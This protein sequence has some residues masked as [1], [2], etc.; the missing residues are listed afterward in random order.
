AQRFHRL[1]IGQRVPDA[2][3]PGDSLGKL[4]PFLG[5]PSLEELFGPL[6]REVE[7]RLHVDDRFAHDAEAK[8]ARLDDAGMHRSY[9]DLV[10]T[11][12]SDL[13]EGEGPTVV[14]E[15]PGRRVLP[16]REVV[17]GPEGMPDQRAG[18]RVPT[19]LN[20]VEIEDLPLES[21]RRIVERGQRGDLRA[22]GG[23]ADRGVEEPMLTLV[24]E[25]I[26]DLEPSTVPAAVVS[27]HQNQIGP[28]APAKPCR[29]RRDAVGRHR[30]IEPR[31]TD[32]DAAHVTSE[33]LGQSRGHAFDHHGPTISAICVSS[34]VTGSGTVSP[35]PTS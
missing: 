4:D 16:E 15:L 33:L 24:S 7:A 19:G 8:V 2:R 35:R 29:Q 30:A 17:T 12:A 20:A 27:D 32:A 23:H 9:W 5:S 22:A 1:A 21:R 28:D 13:L 14:V 31:A 34:R 6:V 25:Q 18:V 3:I 10:D 11:L 26:V